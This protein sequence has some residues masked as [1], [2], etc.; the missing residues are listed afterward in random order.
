MICAL[1]ALQ[2]A[3][4]SAEP[5][6]AERV[7]EPARRVPAHWRRVPNEKPSQETLVIFTVAVKQNNLD[8]LEQ[9][10]LEIA[11]PQHPEFAQHMSLVDLNKLVRPKPEDIASVLSWIE[12]SSLTKGSDNAQSLRDI[13]EQIRSIR[14]AL[15]VNRIA[16]SSNG[17]WVSLTLPLHAVEL[18]LQTSYDIFEHVPTGQRVVR[19]IQ[20]HSTPS[21]V[22]DSIDFVAP[23]N[24]FPHIANH[25]NTSKRSANVQAVGV[26]K[27]RPAIRGHRNHR[28]LVGDD[29]DDES[30]P[31]VG[32][33]HP[34]VTPAL[35]RKMYGVNLARGGDKAQGGSVTN[36]GSIC[37]HH[38]HHGGGADSSKAGGSEA[39]SVAVGS[40][41]VVS[42]LDAHYDP[43][44]LEQFLA[45]FSPLDAGRKPYELR[46]RP[47]T[48][49]HDDLHAVAHKP[50]H[51]DDDNS[52]SS[53]GGGGS[54][55]IGKEASL[56]LQYLM[57]VGSGVPTAVW[58]FHGE[59]D[60]VQGGEK[61][62][63]EPYL[64][65][66]QRLATDPCPPAVMSVSYSDNEGVVNGGE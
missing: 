62:Q 60:V 46:G 2:C 20:Q 10:L 63:C 47:S 51:S 59:I 1:L 15:A 42:F 9:K 43:G 8:R 22:A 27:N 26:H 45:T 38:H 64:K 33:P 17:E 31:A 41:A 50:Q 19:T 57:S 30:S 66:L 40:Q 21:S 25:L 24:R 16:G 49:D 58:L 37:A 11:D 48:N 12:H 7:T 61:H 44:D 28:R 55:S 39:G 5:R 53:A 4:S 36:R 6:V 13:R 65:W 18:L 35:I 56:D 29:D 14:Q 32:D 23:T 52:H 3:F 54:N 34:T